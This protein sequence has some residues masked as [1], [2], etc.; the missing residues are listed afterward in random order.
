MHFLKRLGR[1]LAS[2][3]L[4][5]SLF[6]LASIGALVVVFGTA[7][8]LKGALRQSNIYTSAVDSVLD[9][10]GKQSNSQ[11]GQQA[12]G[13]NGG[14]GLPIDQPGLREAAKTAITPTFL[15]S[16]A[17]QII[18]GIY[19]WLGGKT[20][21]PQ[22][23]IDISTVKQQFTQAMGDYAV[24]R[25]KG[26]PA[27]TPQQARDLAVS[28]PDPL[29]IPC[30]P[31]GFD[32]NSLRA[33]VADQVNKNTG[34]SILQ[35]NTITA[36][37]LPKNDQGQNPV[38]QITDKA[39]KLPQI[40]HWFKLAPWILGGLALLL[41]AFVL[42]LADERRL[43]LKSVAW[44]FIS[45]GAILMLEVIVTTIIAN[46]LTGP[47]GPLAK[48]FNGGN[49]LQQPLIS[50]FHSLGQSV[51][52][53]LL[54]FGIIYLVLGIGTLIILRTTKNEGSKSAVK[55]EKSSESKT[56][57]ATPAGSPEPAQKPAETPKPKPKPTKIQG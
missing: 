5:L 57:M 6:L 49:V 23:S 7:T 27:C 52:G 39:S 25:A 17:E 29:S 56:E 42:L 13:N 1:G 26:L 32:V 40:F 18:D 3:L 47:S 2:S 45:I 48:K 37:N 34:N 14:Q 50:T 44:S 10:A 30:L 21:Q 24:N 41:A 31:T 11:P 43:G 51:N 9:S 55:T 12:S 15:Q 22:F 28:K 38:Q 35:N 20:A 19:G 54:I 33:Q 36:D 8:P 46:K 4:K 16:T 53:K